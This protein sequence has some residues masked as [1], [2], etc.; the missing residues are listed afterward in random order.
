MFQL[1]FGAFCGKP[2][3]LKGRWLSLACPFG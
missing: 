3:K 2:R 1:V